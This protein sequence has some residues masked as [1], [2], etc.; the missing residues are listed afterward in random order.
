MKVEFKAFEYSVPP[1]LAA[2]T[3]LAR[4]CAVLR[5]VFGS[6][7]EVDGSDPCTFLR[8]VSYSP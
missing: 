8:Y 2:T 7:S 5:G 6:K 3:R 1:P 4:C